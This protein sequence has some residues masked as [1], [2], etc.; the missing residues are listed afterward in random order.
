MKNENSRTR[1]S[2]DSQLH[3]SAMG[4][5][6]VVSTTS[7]RLMPST[8]R[9][10]EIPNSGSQAVPLDE[11]VLGRQRIELRPHQEADGECGQRHDQRQLAGLRGMRLAREERGHAAEER[12]Q[13]E[14]GQNRQTHRHR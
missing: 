1:S 10:Y 2:T 9:W 7:S 11:L 14:G 6:N 8:P 5:R 3:S 4:V 13:H 12:Q